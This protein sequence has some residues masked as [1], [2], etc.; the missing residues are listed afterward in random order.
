MT[1]STPGLCALALLVA[2][3]GSDGQADGPESVREIR[4][5]EILVSLKEASAARIWERSQ[6][7]VAMGPAAARAIRQAV[8]SA[9]PEGR[10]CAL[11]ALLELDN[12]AYAAAELAKMAE[13][14]RIEAA[15]RVLA[16]DLL[17][18]S[19]EPDAEESLLELLD[20]LNARIKISAARALWRLGTPRSQKAKDILRDVLKASDPE[21][22]AAGAIALAEIGDADTPGVMETLR[23][24]AREPTE[25]GQLAAALHDKLLYKKT[26]DRIAAREEGGA[27]V[28]PP[29]KDGKGIWAHLD[30]IRTLLD[31]MYAA[32]TPTSVEDLKRRAARGL[33]ELPTDAHTAFMDPDEHR[34]WNAQFNPHYGG[35]GALID[36]NVK[37]DF[38]IARPF[39]GGPAWK[40]DIRTGDSIVAVNGVPTEGRKTE[41]I[42]KQV[43]GPP[44]TTVL[45]TILREGWRA[46]KDVPVI[47]ATIVLPTVLQRM[48]PGKIGYIE[49]ASFGEETGNQFE[50]ELTA[51]EADGLRG[52][53]IDLR[54]NPGGS[55]HTVKQCLTPFLKRGD[56]IC[57]VSGRMVRAESHVAGVPDR[58]R[59][60]PISVLINERSA[61]GA[62]LM[63]GVLQHY[64]TRSAL[65]DAKD[66]YV[67]AVV[68]GE[69]TF[70][71]GTVQYT[72]DLASWPGE[73]FLDEPRRNGEYDP[74]EPFADANRNKRWDA[75]ESFSD[76]PR[77]NGRW[78]EGETW[79]DTNGNGTWDANEKFEDANGDGVWNGPEKFE[80]LNRNGQYDY[81]AAVRMTVARYYL[82]SGK[83]FTR[84][85]VAKDGGFVWEGGVVPDLAL[86]QPKLLASHIA[87]IQEL[88]LAG[89][90]REYVRARWAEHQARFREL[91]YE[92]GRD[93]SRYPGFAEFH[94]ASGTRLTQQEFRRALRLEVRREVANNIGEDIRGD[95]S[96]DFVLR[97][98]VEEVLTRLGVDPKELPEYRSIA[99]HSEE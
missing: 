12:T 94:A 73:P 17:G 79:Q 60:Y 45:L 42:I 75:G 46:T 15:T 37:D 90:L 44:G 51:L 72:R 40:A 69:P 67:D 19:G 77:P 88:Q 28:P 87:E 21:L 96:D 11:R 16:I 65:T 43:K 30:E 63:S 50:K 58:E 54:W 64:S 14:E 1:R 89:T 53:V 74:G 49:I 71:K 20:S 61:S 33:L 36:T 98:G 5:Q 35:I 41:E 25:R 2:I 22:K 26:L 3:L 93:P 78:D 76:L 62:E 8:S 10:L 9:T 95:L 24:L 85:R 32:K 34:E 82:P 80:D 18:E 86:E 91:A 56:L 59:R 66:R 55:L 31:T 4:I 7:L 70:G 47:R 92:D 29:I 6:E 97:R 83:N 84:E 23:E 39:F 57:T 99:E 13:D 38:R 27:V 68:L 52:L 81:G 48:L